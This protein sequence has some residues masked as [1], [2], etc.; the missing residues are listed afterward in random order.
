MIVRTEDE[1]EAQLDE[2]Q[3]MKYLTLDTKEALLKG[4]KQGGA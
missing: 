4:T 1:A 3:R 2:N